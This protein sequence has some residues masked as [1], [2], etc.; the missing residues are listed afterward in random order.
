[1]CIGVS[2][3]AYFMYTRAEMFTSILCRQ[4]WTFRHFKVTREKRITV[5]KL[6][7]LGRDMFV[8]WDRLGVECD[9]KNLL[10]AL[11]KERG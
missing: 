6:F 5:Q 8:Q 10:S 11:E 7:L 2:M 4:T 3:C 1:M 9:K